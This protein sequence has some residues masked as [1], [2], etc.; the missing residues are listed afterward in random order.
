MFRLQV[1]IFDGLHLTLEPAQI[2]KQLLLRRRGAHL[3]QRPAM[4]DVFL[5]GRTNPPH[6]VGCQAKSPIRVEALHSLHHA[7]VAFADQFTDRQAIAAI[8]HGNLCDQA[9]VRRHQLMRCI[10]IFRVTPSL[11]ERQLL[12]WRQHRK[13]ANFL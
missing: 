5:D 8:A 12:V 1:T 13:L 11:G 6:C 4:Q 9:Q 3:H 7:D 10:H 2:E